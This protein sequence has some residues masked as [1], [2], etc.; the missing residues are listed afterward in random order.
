MTDPMDLLRRVIEAPKDF[1]LSEDEWV[2]LD[3][4]LLQALVTAARD[5]VLKEVIEALEKINDFNARDGWEQG[6][7]VAIR[8]AIKT[9]QARVSQQSAPTTS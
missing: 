1:T 8:T 9:L 3:L 5:D 6:Y 7:Q 4:P 2:G